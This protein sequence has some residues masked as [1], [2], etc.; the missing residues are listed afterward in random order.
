MNALY[1]WEGP[2]MLPNSNYN[3]ID[4][5]SKTASDASD[6]AETKTDDLIEKESMPDMLDVIWEADDLGIQGG[7]MYYYPEST[8]K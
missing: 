3:Q 8:D 6:T 2:D 1:L 5:L 7:F 4:D